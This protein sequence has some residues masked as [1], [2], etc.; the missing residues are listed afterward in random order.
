[1][2][3][4][5]RKSLSKTEPKC[6][7]RAEGL[8]ITTL[9]QSKRALLTPSNVMIDSGA[10]RQRNACVLQMHVCVN[11]RIDYLNIKGK[12]LVI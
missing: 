1:M 11:P 7:S 3:K 12:A 8:L 10:K 2:F 6:K 4:S 9:V 5:E